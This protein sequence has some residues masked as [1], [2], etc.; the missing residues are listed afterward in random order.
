VNP[1]VS[2][3]L[4]EKAD[5]AINEQRLTST[6]QELIQIRSE[7]PFD[8]SPAESQGEESVARYMAERFEALGVAY[9]LREL[10]PRRFN[11]IARIGTGEGSASLMLAGHMD[12]VRTVGY[13][14]AYAADVR[15]GR[16]YGR[17]ACDM[18]GALACYLEVLEVLNDLDA[19]PKGTLFV[20]GVADEEYRMLGAQEI[21]ENGPKVDGV[22]VGE[23][24]Q[25]EVCPASRGRVSTFI[26]TRGRAAHSS[27]PETG[28]NAITHMGRVLDALEGYSEQL[29]DRVDPH[30]L[31]G[32]P[33]VNPGVISGG[34]QVNM[35]PDECRLEVDRRTLPGETKETVY[36]E[37]EGIL[38]K[39]RAET[40]DFR[41]HLTEPSWL[42][43][44]NETP[45]DHRLVETL[46]NCVEN[47][48]GERPELRGFVAGAD[49][50]YYGSPAVIC[51]PGSIE[52]AHTTDE[53][54]A[55]EQLVTATRMYLRSTLA[56]LGQDTDEWE[57]KE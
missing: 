21:G 38:A 16:V 52:Q 44:A 34:V 54:V 10:A 20:A 32:T 5:A 8:D 49:A 28:V 22:I 12:A 11:V 31:L 9:E 2:S 4:A 37:L 26:V 50:A 39:V 48:R 7:N 14:D 6:L 1:D 3:G 45:S 53:F 25:L 19:A 30:P 42:I 13:P 27:V 33:R 23:P 47:I 24:T 51:G 29:L 43:P 41:A 46:R 18:K 55:V 57:A 40:P 35:V 56:L 36:E 17:G 15:S